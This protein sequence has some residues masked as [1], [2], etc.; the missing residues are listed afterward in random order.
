[1]PRGEGPVTVLGVN[2]HSTPPQG[3][4]WVSCGPVTA[5]QMGGRGWNRGRLLSGLEP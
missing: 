4:V 2:K 5:H 1:M 3:R